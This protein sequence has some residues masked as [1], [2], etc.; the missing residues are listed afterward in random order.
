MRLFDDIGLDGFRLLAI[1][2][3]IE[4]RHT[5]RFTETAADD[6]VETGMGRG[7]EVAQVGDVPSAHDAGLVSAATGAPQNP[8]RGLLCDPPEQELRDLRS[9]GFL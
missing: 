4:P 3:Y 8:S 2:L 6:L 1:E 9:V 5:A 7:T